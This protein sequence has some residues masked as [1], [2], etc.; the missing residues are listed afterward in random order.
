[1]QDGGGLYLGSGRVT[2]SSSALTGNTATKTASGAI[3]FQAGSIVYLLPAPPGHWLPQTPCEVHREACKQVLSSGFYVPDPDCQAA[4]GACSLLLPA[5]AEQREECTPV[6]LVQTCDWF[7]PGQ[8]GK[9]LYQL[10]VQHVEE[11]FPYPCAAGVLGSADVAQQA[12]PACAGPCPAG[13]L[14][15]RQSTVVPEPCHAGHYCPEGSSVVGVPCPA[16]TYGNATNLASTEQCAV[17]PQ[18]HACATGS[19]LPEPCI[20][21][22]YAGTNGSARCTSCPAGHKAGEEGSS[23]CTPCGSGTHQPL[24]GSRECQP[25]EERT[26]SIAG[27][28]SC[29]ICDEGS[30]RDDH[31]AASSSG[32][33]PCLARAKCPPNSTL[34]T[35]ELVNRTWRP[36]LLS[37]TLIACDGHNCAGG[38]E[39]GND[40]EGYCVPNATGPE[41]K[42]CTSVDHY[43]NEAEGRCEQCPTVVSVITLCAA[44]AGGVVLVL[45]FLYWMLVRPPR[46]MKRF[47][48]SRWAIVVLA[49]GLFDQGPAKFRVSGSSSPR[50]VSE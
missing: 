12:S 50:F 41:C 17:C 28:I 49:L 14:C 44:F 45:L 22:Y 42:L 1:M 39:A 7:V 24:L 2:L 8:L 11:D 6:S 10:P 34:S 38:R 31:V 35:L 33:E 21:G 40:G 3:F 30:F 26:S 32:C 5:E 29:N 23:T 47:A 13:S 27:S 15:P 36:S 19:A 18:G 25:C 16:G 9:E 43:Y 37:R 4:R 46:A 20:G 48:K